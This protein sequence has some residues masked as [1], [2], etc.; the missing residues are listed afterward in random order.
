MSEMPTKV[1]VATET[2]EWLCRLEFLM[3]ARWKGGGEGRRRRKSRGNPHR[4]FF[5][6]GTCCVPAA[7]WSP[8]KWRSVAT[9]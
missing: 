1:H 9:H 5:P 6:S 2:G 8:A 7:T 3:V 4:T